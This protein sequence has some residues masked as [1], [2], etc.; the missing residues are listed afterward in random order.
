MKHKHADLMLLYAQDAGESETPWENWEVCCNK[1]DF[2]LRCIAHPEWETTTQYRRK[3]KTI[4]INGF[5]VP[6]PV[7]KPLAYNDYYYICDL[8]SDR[9]NSVKWTDDHYDLEWLNLGVIHLTS[10]AA[11]L[12]KQALLSFMKQS[13]NEPR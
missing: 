10:E 7:R 6:E 11:E 8:R 1:Y 9:Q 4:N 3:I 12:H 13:G 2:W 5:D